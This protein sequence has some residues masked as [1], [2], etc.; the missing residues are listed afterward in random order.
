[1]A[2]VNKDG[3]SDI[4]FNHL[5]AEGYATDTVF[6]MLGKT[7]LQF[8]QPA[9]LIMPGAVTQMQAGDL[10]ADGYPE[11]L[12]SCTNSKLYVIANGGHDE[13]DPKSSFEVSPNPARNSIKLK[14][15]FTNPYEVKLYSTD[16]RLT[17]AWRVTSMINN[18]NIAGLSSGI[19]FLEVISG[20]ERKTTAIVIQ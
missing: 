4:L 12:V 18:L 14:T 9:F 13:T 1:M 16:G 10:N 6:Y 19:Y 11:W 3:Y 7:N 20:N 5:D 8:G 17:K 2:D 15:N